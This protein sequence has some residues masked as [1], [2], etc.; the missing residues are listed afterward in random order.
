MLDFSPLCIIRWPDCS[1]KD[2]AKNKP[3]PLNFS[4]LHLLHDPQGFAETLF[5]KHLAGNKNRLT[6]EQKLLVLQLVS[7][8]IGL[9]KLHVLG[10]YS[11]ILKY[12]TPRQRDVTRFLI[13]A[14]HATHDLVPPDSLE[15][16]VRKI[17][18]EFVSEGVAGEVATAGLNSIREICARAPLA[19]N[20]TLLQDLTEY[21][22]SKDKG[23]MMGARSLIG[24]YREIAPEMLKRKD[25]GKIA[26]MEMKER[27]GPRYG[28]EKEG[29]IEGLDLLEKWKEEQKAAKR[30]ERGGGEDDGEEEDDENAWAQ[31][32]VE[33][34]SDDD[35]TGWI[36]VESD[37]EDINI[38]DS[39][40]E[41]DSVAKKHKVGTDDGN[42]TAAGERGFPR[43][44]ATG[45]L[46]PADFAKLEEL[47][48]QHGLERLTGKKQ[49]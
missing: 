32:E 10:V 33:E 17:A 28:E 5:S 23:V 3:H 7:R 2:K 11:Y 27:E 45:I 22:G 24:L 15:P 1:Q 48:Q 35:G 42:D 38:S 20:A 43:L 29:V 9:H 44:A 21:K 4:A 36:N 18:D 16:I 26:S 31:W 6:M 34:D 37:G 14:A 39:E 49:K 12:L 40:D 19:M 41:G 47:R 30:A 13:C 46:T 25:R 8:L